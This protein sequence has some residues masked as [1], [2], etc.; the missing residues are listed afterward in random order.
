MKGPPRLAAFLLRLTSRD[1]DVVDG[2]LGDLEEDLVGLAESG[3]APRHR[4]LWYWWALL[5]PSV[6]FT[7][8]RLTSNGPGVSSSPGG[9]AKRKPPMLEIVRQDFTQAVRSLRRDAGL[10][11][12]AILIVGLG[13]GACSTVFSVANA[14]LIR[15]LPF[16]DPEEL[17]L[18]SN[19][20]WGR[21]QALSGISVQVS[22]LWALQNESRLLSEVAGYFLFDRVGDHTLTGSGEPERLS[23][24]SVTTNFLPL[25]GV[26]PQMGRVF[27]E[28]EI[29]WDGPGAIL[30]T[31]GFWVR[32]FGADPGVL[33]RALLIDGEPN[34]VVGILPASF[35]FPTVFAPGSRVD[36][37]AGFPLN[38]ET[39][40]QGN[41]L[42]LVGRLRSGAAPQAVEAEAALLAQR[43]YQ[44]EGYQSSF[45]PRVTSLRT[46]VSG[47]FR[48]AVLLLAGAVGLVMLIVCTN[49]SNLLLARGVTRQK[50]IAI[51]AALG[52]ERRRILCQMLAES[53]VLALVG[54]GL[55]LLLAWA[56]TRI[57]SRL[58]ATIPLLAEVRLDGAA[59]GVTVGMAVLV[60]IVF[61]LAPAVRLSAV[62][63]HESLS[64]TGRGQSSGRRGA[65]L[66]GTLVVSQVALCC[67]LLVGAGLLMRS[68]LRVLDVDLGFR[69]Q[70]VVA[71]RVDHDSRLSADDSPPA[72]YEE[73]LRRVGSAPGIE[74]AAL[75]DVLPTTFNRRW[76]VTLAEDPERRANPYVRVVSEGFLE[77]MG[78]SLVAGRDLSPT[79]D[80]SGGRVI[81]VNEPLARSFWPD[82]D[83]VGKRITLREDDYE[84]VGVVQGMRHLHPEQEPGPEIFFPAR[85]QAY[86]SLAMPHV[87]A[88][89]RG[90]PARIASALRGALR[91]M[92][93]NLP[94]SEIV[95]VQ[96]L[97]NRSLSPRRFVFLL[98]AGFAGFAL[99][100]AAL[101]LYG[102]ISFSVRQRTR[103]IGIRSALGAAP[104]DL[105]R[106]VLSDTLALTGA[107]MAL[108][109]AAAWMLGQVFQGLLFGVQSSDP[110]TFLSV[111]ALVLAVAAMAGFLPASRAT[112]IDPVRALGG[113]RRSGA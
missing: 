71:L 13:I 47:P 24:L 42:A 65:W 89:G 34:T 62:E 98:L 63:L 44:G 6:R 25:L 41:T 80:G 103:E 2:I 113:E 14:L 88:R 57:L 35:D 64:E 105:M 43:P 12:V 110:A 111:G 76:R 17:V 93:E 67:V 33:G 55:G 3:R 38:E 5:G 37:L 95:V 108:G 74:A 50:D 79:D 59:L 30:L 77:A 97:L 4:R 84:V 87:V 66:R 21:G 19:G 18:I 11:G 102:L 45:D 82:E 49:L 109:L 8:K 32:R 31:H 56:G 100:L 27:R 85:Q 16:E 106:R 52:A 78:L 73:M 101:G 91:P 83:A 68:F 107:G 112:R 40:L 72:Y 48:S 51:R 22:H 81:L 60:G 28:D 96:D 94:V 70:G 9:R 15:P 58:D 104:A 53:G 7:V 29:R 36:F 61:G 1:P 20:E 26:Q 86:R 69:P 46:H 54:A 23:R 75:T 99:F 39:N 92:D 10:A 90:S